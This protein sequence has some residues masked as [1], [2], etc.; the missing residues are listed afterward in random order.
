[1]SRAAV[2][3]G[4]GGH[5]VGW[6]HAGAQAGMQAFVP[7]WGR[8]HPS[9]EGSCMHRG[10]VAMKQRGRMGQDRP[11]L[12]CRLELWTGLGDV[13][14]RKRT[15]T[16]KVLTMSRVAGLLQCIMSGV[17]RSSSTRGIPAARLLCGRTRGGQGSG[18]L[19][20]ASLKGNVCW[21]ARLSWVLASWPVYNTA[22]SHASRLQR[23]V[24]A[25]DLVG[26]N[27]LGL[28]NVGQGTA[29]ARGHG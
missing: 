18:L 2:A 7:S 21:R 13:R 14:V 12:W 8:S 29:A 27:A 24:A 6:G 10:R 16:V 26:A 28:R 23:R 25:H 1:M 11:F 17:A 15:I 20:V 9:R 22:T 19:H 5:A 3:W 4:R